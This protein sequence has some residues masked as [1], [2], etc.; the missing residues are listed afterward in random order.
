MKLI[1]NKDELSSGLQIIQS[2]ISAKTT[3]PVLSNFLVEA[4]GKEI[5]FS[6]T[7]LEISIQTIVTGE[8]VEE[9]EIT[10]PAKKFS[11]II[12]E[13]PLKDEISVDTDDTL[14]IDIQC[15]KIFF[16][17]KGLSKEEFPVI[18]E[19]TSSKTI[20]ISKKILENM[21]RKTIFSVSNDETR[22]VLNGLYLLFKDGKLIVVATDG[23]RLSFM[24]QEIAEKKINKG[25]IVPSKT[26]HELIKLFA[27]VDDK[28]DIKIQI[29]DN[30]AAFKFND[31]AVFSRLVEGNFPNYEQ[32]IPKSSSHKLTL[33]TEELLGVT[34]RAALCVMEKGGS[35][36]YLIGKNNLQI[37]AS[38]HQAIEYKDEIDIAY[39]GTSVE[40][41]FN[42]VYVIDIL[43]NVDTKDIAFE[44]TSSVNPGVIKPT[45]GSKFVYIIM[46]MKIS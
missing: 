25:I 36:K 2:A 32:V 42:P 41:A 37:S 10:I 3:L 9:G 20:S 31:T 29:L 39:D 4:K 44:F 38:S 13:L 17:M 43:K 11:D 45:N 27:G 46:P 22:Y 28:E 26:I 6:S 40:I 8:V 15:K 35:V 33:N 30:Q 23:R 16:S 1:F 24:E 5:K 21:F 19:F 7:N 12:K 18:P 14:K 34:K